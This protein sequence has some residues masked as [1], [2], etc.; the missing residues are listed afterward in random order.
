MAYVVR[1]MQS[2]SCIMAT[3]QE[4]TTLISNFNE[5]M[6]AG[7]WNSVVVLSGR[8]IVR[9]IINQNCTKNMKNLSSLYLL[10]YP[11]PFLC[12]QHPQMGMCVFGGG[13]EQTTHCFTGCSVC[14]VHIPTPN[15]C[16]KKK[17]KNNNNN[18]GLNEVIIFM[19][20]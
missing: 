12:L 15:T 19:Q 1:S 20:L 7:K 16:K 5:L 3:T 18:E 10:H 4:P 14:I 6:I 13:G 2:I 17:Y 8:F 9:Q 11:S